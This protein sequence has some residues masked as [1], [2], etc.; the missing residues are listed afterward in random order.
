MVHGARQLS[1]KPLGGRIQGERVV[2]S[3]FS[4]I[5][6]P[7]E[8][9]EE[10]Q[11]LTERLLPE[12]EEHRTSLGRYVRYAS[13]CGAELWFQVDA[14][15]ELVGVTPY[16]AAQTRLTVGLTGSVN[17]P[18]DTPLEGALQ[19]WASPSADEPADSGHYPFV[20]DCPDYRLYGEI[21][22]P[23]VAQASIAAF[24]HELSFFRSIE[25]FNASQSEQPGFA[26]QSFIPSGLF[27]PDG[28]S[29]DPPRSEALLTGHVRAA[30]KRTN[31]ATGKQYLS[32]EVESYGGAFHVV[33]DPELVSEP[34]VPGG[35]VQGSF[36]LCGRLVTLPPTRAARGILRRL[37]SR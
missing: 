12:C 37:F 2:P 13:P 14:H 3:H 15:D 30:A 21:A 18:D 36:W 29:H 27:S 4:S 9:Q 25:E 20:F 1:A 32:A 19:A 6:F 31:P 26:S 7:L 35:V 8:S 23:T 5:G 16:F 22:F 24:A 28:E 10:L 11:S 33:S 34:L 17:R